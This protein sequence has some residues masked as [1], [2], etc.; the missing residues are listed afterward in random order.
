MNLIGS[1][2]LQDHK[3]FL[4]LIKHSDNIESH[5]IG[6]IQS[7]KIPKI[8]DNFDVIQTLGSLKHY[9]K[10]SK[11]A[12]SQKK[13]VPVLIEINIGREENKSGIIPEDLNLFLNTIKADLNPK[14]V[15]IH[16]FM[17]MG[18]FNLN[19]NEKRNEFSEFRELT[20]NVF[21]NYEFLFNARELSFGMSDDFLTAIEFGA[22]IVRLGTILFGKRSN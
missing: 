13:V 14:F 17:T 16:G 21:K 9:R 5:Y 19:T 10:I 7:A 15:P 2:Y 1:N 6:K 3:R 8:V 11:Y 12:S 4:P 18:R 22:T 20:Y